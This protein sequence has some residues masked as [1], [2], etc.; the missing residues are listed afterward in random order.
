MSAKGK[1]AIDDRIP[2][3][4]FRAKVADVS[5]PYRPAARTMTQVIKL[6]RYGRR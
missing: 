6:R 2:K 5:P 1:G 4:D 3:V